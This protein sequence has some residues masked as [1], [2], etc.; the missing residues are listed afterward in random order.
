MMSLLVV[1]V[2]V[3]T[4]LVLRRTVVDVAVDVVMRWRRRVLTDEVA[5]INSYTKISP[6]VSP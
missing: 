3:M 1:G 6:E 2:G 4:S 5:S